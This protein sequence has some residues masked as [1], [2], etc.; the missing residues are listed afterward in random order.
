MAKTKDLSELTKDRL[1]EIAQERDIE[2]RSSMDKDEL[3]EALEQSA[4]GGDG[5]SGDGLDR[6]TTT[7][8]AVWRGAISF[9]LITIPVG[10]YSATEDR[11]I[12][13]HLLSEK[14][15]S[16][17]KYKRVS[18]KSGKEVD[19]DDI[20]K[21]YE[22]EEGRYVTFTDEEL[23]RI[24][25]DSIRAVD[26]VQF[27]KREE[28]DP[29]YFERT[30]YLAPEE[31]AVKA[32]RVLLEALKSAGRVGIGKVTI[33]EKERLCAIRPAEDVLALETMKWPDEVRVPV[34]DE[35]EKDVRVSPQEVEMAESLIS[36]LS[37]DFD[38][39]AFH[40]SYRER[41]EEAIQAKIEGEEVRLAPEEPEPEKVTDLLEALQASVE[42]T[43]RKSA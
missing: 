30:Y 6:P 35:L 29:I 10:L 32:Y 34:F 20:V 2:G 9:G 24:P 14:D 7:Q 26:V 43:R 5:S 38:P 15:G 37:A 33:R 8:R 18:S 28:I 1:Y 11:D 41:L 36:H 22:Y 42:A 21:G 19:W 3:V 4:D 31:S 40:D 12:S 13:F 27:V 39:A 17:I 25:S 23:E 16:R